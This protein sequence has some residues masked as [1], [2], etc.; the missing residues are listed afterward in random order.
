MVFYLIS[1]G[2]ENT[3]KIVKETEDRCCD[4]S[5]EEAGME[6]VNRLFYECN[7]GKFQFDNVINVIYIAIFPTD[8]WWINP[9]LWLVEVKENLRKR[10]KKFNDFKKQIAENGPGSDKEMDAYDR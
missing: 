1:A 6:L 2:K 10:V 8:L 3:S 5:S 4:R 9:L 7:T